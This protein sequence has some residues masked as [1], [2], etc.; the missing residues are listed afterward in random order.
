MLINPNRRFYSLCCPAFVEASGT[1]C[2]ETEKYFVFLFGFIMN[3]WVENE[4]VFCKSYVLCL[5]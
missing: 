1:V 3:D 5:C 2:A 4:Y